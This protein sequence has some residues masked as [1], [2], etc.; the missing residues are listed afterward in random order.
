MIVTSLSLSLSQVSD[1][2]PVG[3]GS[4]WSQITKSVSD[5]QLNSVQAQVGV[6]F[7][8]TDNPFTDLSISPYIGHG[9]GILQIPE[10]H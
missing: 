5:Y 8:S 2:D 3:G 9:R 6:V 4:L 10:V 7:S 1:Q